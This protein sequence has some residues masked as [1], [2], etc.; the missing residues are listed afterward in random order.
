MQDLRKVA[1]DEDKSWWPQQRDQYRVSGLDSQCMLNSLYS[2][3][4]QNT[5]PKNRHLMPHRLDD[6]DK[7]NENTPIAPMNMN[8]K[9]KYKMT[10]REKQALISKMSAKD[11][12]WKF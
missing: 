3:S 6:H 9:F 7:V 12:F 4:M 11:F 10:L 1:Q 5:I 8:I 2:N